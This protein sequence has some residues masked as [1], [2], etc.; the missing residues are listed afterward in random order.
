MSDEKQNEVQQLMIYTI[1]PTSRQTS[2]GSTS[3]DMSEFSPCLGW[4]TCRRAGSSCREV[5]KAMFEPRKAWKQGRTRKPLITVRFFG[6]FVHLLSCFIF[7][8]PASFR[9]LSWFA[10]SDF[11]ILWLLSSFLFISRTCKPR[12]QY[13]ADGAEKHTKVK[14]WQLCKATGKDSYG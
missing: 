1:D 7:L 12:E 6:L 5:D 9:P 13:E 4:V 14:T 11:C 8:S 2:W 3:Y 10:S